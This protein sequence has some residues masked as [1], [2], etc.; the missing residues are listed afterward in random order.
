M[1]FSLLSFGVIA[2]EQ[3]K[4][5]VAYEDGYEIFASSTVGG[6]ISPEGY[7]AVPAG[8]SITYTM[9]HKAGYELSKVIVDGV[10]IGKVTFFTFNNVNANHTI[11][12]VFETLSHSHLAQGVWKKDSISH[13]KLCSCKVKPDKAGHLDDDGDKNVMF[14]FI[15]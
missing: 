1:I 8:N 2:T 3:E 7:T 12:V 10:D 5:P 11:Q 15:P 9:T 4:T 6:S 14:V 13:W